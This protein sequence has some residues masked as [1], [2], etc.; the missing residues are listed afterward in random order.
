MSPLF[1]RRKKDLLELA[2]KFL[3][4]NLSLIHI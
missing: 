2:M 3:E 1:R 4:E